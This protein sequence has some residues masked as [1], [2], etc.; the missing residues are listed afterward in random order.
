MIRRLTSDAAGFAAELDALLAWDVAQSADVT[1]AAQ[2]I[3]QDVRVRGDAALLEHTGKLDQLDVSD[4]AALELP[5]EAL[6]A[7]YARLPLADR[8]ALDGAAR[9]IRRYHE[10][11]PDGGFEIADEEGN[12]LGLRVTPLD[13]VGVYVPG[14]QAAYPSTALMT[15]VPARVAGVGEVIVATPTPG[16][17]RSDHLL[18][19]LF[20][21]GP[22][23]VFTIGGAQAIAALAYGTETVPQV[24]KIV[25]PGGAFVTAAKRL[26]FGPVGIDSLAGPSEVVVIADG[27]VAPT[28]TALDLLAQA[29]HDAAAQAILLSP[30][31]DYLD[32]VEH[33]ANEAL[34]SLSR[35]DIIRDSLASRGALIQ[36]RDLSDACNIANRI[37]PEHLELAV[38]DPDAL[39]PHIRHAGAIFLGGHAAEVIG[40]YSAGPSHV[41]PTFGTA[42]YASPLSVTDFQKRT[43][44]VRCDAAG[45]QAP[46]RLAATVAEAEG[47]SA[48]AAAAKARIGGFDDNRP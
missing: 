11:Q 4:A 22:D 37:A 29:E 10:A 34:H 20:I 31:A 21:A 42:R 15:I 2:D 7:S 46:A 30:D 35:A 47:L 24:H 40:D 39:L 12:T 19:A 27:S 5:A 9:R 38:R 28:W 16:G 44:I 33:S 45:V 1:R 6:E 18:A 3:V 41:L 48:H 13:R 43:S 17:E 23:R 32:R 36:T 14:G 25:G 8:E 26:V